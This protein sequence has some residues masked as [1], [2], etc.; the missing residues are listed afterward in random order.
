M[1]QAHSAIDGDFVVCS[2]SQI[3]NEEKEGD[4]SLHEG[5]K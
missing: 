2:C 3:I 4:G 1:L 5:T